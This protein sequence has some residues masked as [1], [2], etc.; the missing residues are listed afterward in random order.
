MD[1]GGKINSTVLFFFLPFFLCMG[2]APH[3]SG[4]SGAHNYNN[5]VPSITCSI[6]VR[7]LIPAPSPSHPGKYESFP[8]FPS[9]FVFPFPLLRF[10]SFFFLVFVLFHSCM[11]LFPLISLS[12]S[13]VLVFSYFL[14]PFLLIFPF[15]PFYPMASPFFSVVHL[16]LFSHRLSFII[17]SS[18]YLILF[19]NSFL[20]FPIL[21]SHLFLLYLS[22]LNFH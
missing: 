7:D 18:T 21:S 5:P 12:P 9:I 20:S 4:G 8:S 16:S 13:L 14:V 19:L 10:S 3:Q 1:E 22:F 11:L 2:A 6:P 17:V 15:P